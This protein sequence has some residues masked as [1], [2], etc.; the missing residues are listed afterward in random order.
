MCP[1]VAGVWLVRVV[2]RACVLIFSGSGARTCEL[3]TGFKT[4]TKALLWEDVHRWLRFCRDLSRYLVAGLKERSQKSK[5]AYGQVIFWRFAP[6][7][8][9]AE[10]LCWL[11]EN[12]VGV[13]VPSIEYAFDHDLAKVPL[14]PDPW[15]LT[16]PLTTTVFRMHLA[17]LVHMTG[18]EF[19]VEKK[20][21]SLRIGFAS[22]MYEW[23]VP[24][25]IA[26]R[27]MRYSKSQ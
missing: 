5:Y 15:D 21:Y 13:H 11:L 6:P 22:W 8:D 25:D 18:L 26:C 4:R 3:L 27:C 7:I 12:I 17:P 20:P 14:I 23:G 24:T 2:A 10:C 16:V 9:C 1:A 19:P